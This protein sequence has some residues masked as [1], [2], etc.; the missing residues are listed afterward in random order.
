MRSLHI[1]QEALDNNRFRARLRF[2]DDGYPLEAS[3]EFEFQLTERDRRDLRWYLENY[4][5][6]PAA[7][8]PKSPTHLRATCPD[9]A[10]GQASR[11]APPHRPL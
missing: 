11:P 10:F 8:T 6:F 1:T 9:P 5:Q 2:N 4:L 3:P 7:P